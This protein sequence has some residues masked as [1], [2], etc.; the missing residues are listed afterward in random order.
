VKAYDV[1]AFTYKADIFCDGCMLASANAWLAED[2]VKVPYLITEDALDAWAT[3]IRLDRD[4]EFSFDSDDFPKVVFASQ[5]EDTEWCGE[6]GEEI[7]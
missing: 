5:V 2:G 6:C 4:D 1:L 7:L 3:S